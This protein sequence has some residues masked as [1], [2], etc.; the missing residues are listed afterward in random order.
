[1]LS[2][3]S[4]LVAL[5]FLLACEGPSTPQPALNQEP[6]PSPVSTLSSALPP[7]ERP[8][9]LE[10][11]RPALREAF[12]ADLDSMAEAT[13]YDL[14]LVVD[15]DRLQ[16]LGREQV[17]Y[18]NREAVPLAAIYMRLFPN[19][20]GC[21]GQV[22]ITT[23]LVQGEPVTARYEVSRTALRIPMDPSLQ[24]GDQVDLEL[25]FTVQI[26]EN[27][28]CRYADFT[29]TNGV[30]ALAHIYPQIPV[31]DDEGW[32]IELAPNYGDLVYADASLYYVTATMPISLVVAAS[33]VEVA[34]T[35]AG[36]RTKTVS[37]VLG[38]ARDFYLALSPDYV[39]KARQIGDVRLISY[40]LPEHERGGELVL[41]YAEHALRTYE[42]LFGPYRYP[43]L[44]IAET[45]T[46]AGGIEYPGLIVIAGDL[47]EREGGF[48]EVATVHEVAHQWWYNIVGNDQQDEPW[49]DEA[50]ATYSSIVYFE[51]VE[52]EEAGQ[53]L[54]EYYRGRHQELLNES[55]DAP[56]NL[57]VAG[58]SEANYSR[59]VYAKGALFFDALR[60][61]VGDAAF[62]RILQRYYERYLYGI[63][64]GEGFLE[65]AKQTSGKDLSSLYKLWIGP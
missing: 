49:V 24:P 31:Y 61:E 38:P 44:E 62:W 42:D 60:R 53:S 48:F 55:E 2:R 11:F 36:E 29:Y 22:E 21:G 5:F 65:I 23:L 1:M 4:A 41:D 37:W 12:A 59:A 3:L 56:V 43:E 64:T 13:R 58:Y 15:A 28:T 63:A 17:L 26:P 51:K 18:T 27:E 34:H 47:Y 14:E 35:V 39:T 9:V 50:L 57:P 16:V 19:F 25:G 32:N 33:G 10:E 20:P 46:L 7:T 8:A 52:G 40:Y 54:L 45:A 30:L 6:S